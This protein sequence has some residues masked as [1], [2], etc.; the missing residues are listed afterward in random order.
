MASDAELRGVYVPL[1]TPFRADGAVALDAVERLCNEYLEAGAAGIVAL[2]T[3]GEA[4][5]L[6]AGEKRAVIDACGKVCRDRRA[7]LIVGAGTNNTKA[8]VAAVE[9]LR[10]V[11][12]LTA[13]LAVVPYY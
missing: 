6:D 5:A 3:T 12:G 7:Q 10:G 4:A 1:I 2:G 9:Q 13:I 11:D 8:S